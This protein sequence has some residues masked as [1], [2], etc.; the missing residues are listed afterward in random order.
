M[1]KIF[2]LLIY[3]V[4]STSLGYYCLIDKNYLPTWYFGRGEAMNFYKDYPRSGMTLLE[5]IY[6]FECIG[7]HLDNFVSHL[8]E[9]KRGNF[10]EFMLHHIATL[11]L[12]VFSYMTCINTSGLVIS[13][14]HDFSDIMTFVI[15]LMS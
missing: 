11:S 12:L 2:H 7:L 15:R 3:F 8:F 10:I 4:M 13:F 6:Y 14:L 1:C 5:R 9:P